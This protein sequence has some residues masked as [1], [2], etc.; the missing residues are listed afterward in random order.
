MDVREIGDRIEAVLS[1]GR[2]VKGQDGFVAFLNPNS[3]QI[4]SLS[5]NA[6]DGA[7]RY[8]IDEIDGS[9]YVFDAMDWIHSDAVRALSLE[10]DTIGGIVFMGDAVWRRHSVAYDENPPEEGA[11]EKILSNRHF[12]R[13]FSRVLDEIETE[14]IG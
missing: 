3:A 1:E 4:D 5:R 9:L 7:V 8:V 12:R 13:A 6:E 10:G 2:L 11:M 14:E